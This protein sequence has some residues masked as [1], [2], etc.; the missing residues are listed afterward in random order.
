MNDFFDLSLIDLTELDDTIMVNEG[1]NG[2]NNLLQ[3]VSVKVPPFWAQGP[4]IWFAQVEAQFSNAKISTDDDKFNTVVGAIETTVL[5][6]VR[7]AVLNPTE[8]TK[9]ENLKQAML[10]EFVDSDYTRMKKL[11]S[12]LSLGDN[13]PSFL[14]NDMRR[15]GG[16]NVSDDVLKT[17]WMSLL[18]VQIRTVLATSTATL[19]ELATLADKVAEVSTQGIVQQIDATQPTSS[20]DSRLCSMEKQ[21]NQLVSAVNFIKNQGGRSRSRSFSSDKQRQRSQTPSKNR[22]DNNETSDLCWYHESYGNKADNCKGPPC[23][24]FKP[25]N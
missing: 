15:L 2:Q 16:A 12:E 17:L 22:S 5:N 9:Y 10:K 7:N 24:K 14:L 6:R 11:F 18:P 21:I 4:D 20:T 25:K 23:P 1:T 19:N 13:K 3:R 8:G